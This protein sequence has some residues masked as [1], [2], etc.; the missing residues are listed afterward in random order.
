MKIVI[1]D[2]KQ[3]V[4]DNYLFLP[5]L[6]VLITI[7]MRYAYNS[8]TTGIFIGVSILVFKKK[9]FRLEKNLIV[10]IVFYLLMLASLIWTTDE[11]ETK[12]ALFKT[13][14]FLLL[15]ACFMINKPLSQVQ[16]QKII[17]YYGYA[18]VLFAVFYLVRAFVSYCITKESSVFFYHGLV[19]EDVNAI[20]VSVYMVLA[21]FSFMIEPSKTILEKVSMLLLTGVIV[22]LSSKNVLIVFL[23]LNLVYF[24]YRFESK[25]KMKLL[26]F[27]AGIGLMLSLAFFQKIKS[28]FEIE[29]SSNIN[30]NTINEDIVD[31]NAL[32]VK[33]ISVFEAWND[34]TFNR[35]DFFPGTALRVYQFRIFLEM[36]KTDGAYLTGYGLNAT[37]HKIREK[38]IEHNLYEGYDEFNFHNQYV[39][40]FAEL[41]ILGFLLLLTM[42]VITLKKALENKDF[43]HISFA[44]L[45]ISL[46]LTESFLSR[47]RGIVF[48]VAFYCFFN[49]AKAIPSKTED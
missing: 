41:G 45:M 17:R 2:I 8:I 11:P 10:P 47:Q 49:A 39:Q 15:P 31:P 26:I 44:V 21:Y 30:E 19:T 3:Q 13:L 33:N 27:G 12:S 48:F 37:K 22:L 46:F 29:F 34:D 38:R 23:I 28:R 42:V 43:V 14:P 35:N 40:F 5:L 20:H 25:N 4:K 1:S 32:V 36:M 7:P 16:T 9:H 6:L 24:F 18:F